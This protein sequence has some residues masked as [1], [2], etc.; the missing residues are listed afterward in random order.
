MRLAYQENGQFFGLAAGKL[1]KL[2][3]EELR[4]LGVRRTHDGYRGVFFEA[5]PATLYRVNYESRLL[6]R[7]LAPLTEFQCHSDRYLYTQAQKIDWS[8][9]LSLD[10]T[11]AVFATVSNSKIRHSQFA[12]RRLKDA[13]VDQF[14]EATGSRPNVQTPNPDVWLNLHIHANRATISVD[15]SGGS[16]HRR[17]YRVEAVKAPMQ[18][19][20]AAAALRFSG[21]DGSEPLLDPMCGSG[22][23][24]AEALMLAARI[25]AGYLRGRF[26][27]EHLPDFDAAA[28]EAVREKA[29]AAIREV[30]AGLIRGS[31][32]DAAAI[33]AAEMNLARLPS[34]ESVELSRRDFRSI[35]S[36]DEGIILTN[37]P[38]GLRLGDAD[39]AGALMRDL[40]DWLKQSCTGRS[41]YV[42]A[43]KP[44]MLKSVGLRTT[45]KKALVNGALEGRLARYDLFKGSG[46]AGK[47]NPA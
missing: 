29:D 22:T 15:T 45:W 36:V 19:T 10:K 14:R 47:A 21:W 23:L 13:I 35:A 42:Y 31:D 30:P 44:E 4:E 33:E 1:E 32:V 40:G 11:F 18:E 20:V 7:V 17:G 38:Y 27:F 3:A 37:P 43:G 8:Q 41:A 25:P 26:G 39:S 24:L 28:W 12:A 46:K 34:G 6:T 16:L 2:A 9:L 5:D